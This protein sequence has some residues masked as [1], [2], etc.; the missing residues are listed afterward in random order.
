MCC[1]PRW[2][3]KQNIYA[4]CG[5]CVEC[6]RH[7]S[8]EW[9]LRIVLEASLYEK[10]CCVT[11]T[12]ND[13]NLPVNNLLQPRD[14]QL[15]MKSLRKAI[16]P[17]RV[18]FFASGEYGLK[19]FRPHYHV[20]LFGYSPDDLVYFFTRDGRDFYKSQFIA[21]IW[22]RG[23]ILVGEVDYHTAFYTAKYL[24]KAMFSDVAVPPFVRMSNRPGIGAGAVDTVNWD[25]LI[26]RAIYYHG[27]K[28][29]I[30]RYFWKVMEKADPDIYDWES[31][32]IHNANQSV[33][34][35]LRETTES[36][37]LRRKADERFWKS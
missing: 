25:M 31:M 10:N 33:K 28:Y 16:S 5:K 20:I 17:V 34:A 23:H 32:H 11:L 27:K 7:V 2:L 14:L 24:Q 13:E 8:S 19:K 29:S 21:D 9:A 3:P 15:F 36:I 12:Y 37:E 18:R 35:H 1:Y 4:P 26:D 6:M 30:P 22:K